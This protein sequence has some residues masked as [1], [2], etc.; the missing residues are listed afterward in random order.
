MCMS[1]GGFKGVPS[2]V[3]RVAVVEDGGVKGGA[4]RKRVERRGPASINHTSI[5][6]RSTRDAR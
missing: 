2:R 5:A 6:A 3:Q 4:T 1:F